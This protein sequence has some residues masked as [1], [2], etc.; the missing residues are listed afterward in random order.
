MTEGT[1]RMTGDMPAVMLS[2]SFCHV[3]RSETSPAPA[4]S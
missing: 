3:E 1:L 2:V 4:V